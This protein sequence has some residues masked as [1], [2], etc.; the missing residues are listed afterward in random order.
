MSHQSVT[1]KFPTGR[2]HLK[3]RRRGRPPR[4]DQMVVDMAAALMEAY[5]LGPQRAHDLALAFAEGRAVTPAKLPPKLPRGSR[6]AAQGSLL[7][8]YE[9]PQTFEGRSATIAQKLR[10]GDIRPRPD[11]VAALVELL[12]TK[13]DGIIRRAHA[14]MRLLIA[15]STSGKPAR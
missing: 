4:D 1:A 6:K 8:V 13:D 7:V 5:G 9:L 14:T 11:V 12:R 3:P 2:R 10:R 15:R